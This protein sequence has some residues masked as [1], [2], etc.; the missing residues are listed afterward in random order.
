[1]LEG[2]AR[3][4]VSLDIFWPRVVRQRA[5]RLDKQADRGGLGSWEGEFGVLEPHL[6][7]LAGM[8]PHVFAGTAQPQ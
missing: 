2:T 6:L 7:T 5:H 4:Q 1:M 8:K 3:N